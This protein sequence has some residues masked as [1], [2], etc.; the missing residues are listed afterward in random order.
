MATSDARKSQRGRGVRQKKMTQ[1]SRIAC[2]AG[3]RTRNRLAGV[4]ATMK[5]RPCSKPA[6]PSGLQVRT[7]HN[8]VVDR[9]TK[10]GTHGQECQQRERLAEHWHCGLN[11][12]SE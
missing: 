8:C 7:E 9:G 11:D 1:R 5:C 3:D 6:G 4:A 2:V 12:R 10:E